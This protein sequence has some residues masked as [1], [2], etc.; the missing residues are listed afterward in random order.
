M[1]RLT[2]VKG[3]RHLL[4]AMRSVQE[5]LGYRLNL[6][7]IGMGP[8]EGVLRTLARRA[9]FPVEFIGW[10]DGEQRIKKLEE[11]DLLAVP[12]LWPEPFGLVGLEAACLGIPAV[13]F[14][15]GGI[16]DWLEDGVTGELAP[17]DPPTAKGLAA[18]IVRAL[19]DPAHYNR[20]RRGAWEIAHEFG[21][22]NHLAKLES[23]LTSAASGAK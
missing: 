12:S 1:G 14:N 7:I 13:A 6:T 3:L 15:A 10:A 11:C 5:T 19:Q 4:L 23:I 9:Q 18:A 8:E 22:G 17:G 2:R 20:L 16:P 21:K